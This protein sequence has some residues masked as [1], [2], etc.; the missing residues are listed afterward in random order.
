MK[1][2]LSPF[3][4][5][6]C[7]ASTLHLA[8]DAKS[9]PVSGHGSSWTRWQDDHS[10][11]QA[12]APVEGSALERRNAHRGERW[13]TRERSC[14]RQRRARLGTLFQDQ[15]ARRPMFR[16]ASRLQFKADGKRKNRPDGNRTRDAPAPT[17]ALY[18]VTNALESAYKQG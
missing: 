11:R 9:I 5:V 3:R 18:H 7:S 15:V 14:R 12:T 8:V 10:S 16:A 13:R 6:L 4:M 2:R 1:L 17:R